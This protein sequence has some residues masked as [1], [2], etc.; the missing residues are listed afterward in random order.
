[1]TKFARTVVTHAHMRP[2]AASSQR[3]NGDAAI[4]PT[5]FVAKAVF[6]AVLTTPNATP[7]TADVSG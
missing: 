3:A 4:K 5:P 1:M 6:I 2:H 7:L